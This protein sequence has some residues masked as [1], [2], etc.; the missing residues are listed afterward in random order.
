MPTDWDEL[1][2]VEEPAIEVLKALGYIYVPPEELDKEREGVKDVI[3]VPRLEKALRRINPWISDENVKRAVRAIGHVQATSLMEANEQV[4]TALVHTISLEQDIGQG[5]KG[6]PVHFIDFENIGN[7]EFVVTR[8]FKVIGQK[9]SIQADIVIYVNG[10]PLAV[11]ECKS[12]TI[13][14]PVEEGITQL[15]RY[16]ESDEKYKGLGAPKLFESCQIVAVVCRE[17]ARY[18][19]LWTQPRFWSEWKTTFPLSLDEIK[20]RIGRLP[21]EQDVLLYG[22]L[23]HGNLLNLIRDFIVFDIEKGKTIKKLARY[24]QF[25][26]VSHA[27]ERIKKTRMPKK[28]GG[29]VWHTQG[30][31][32]SLTML[33]LA[34]KLRRMSEFENPTLII[35]TDRKDL[36]R[37]INKTFKNC[38]FAN[39][40]RAKS[41]E[42]LRNLLT[43]GIGQ[44]VLTTIQKFTDASQVTALSEATNIF[45]MTDEAHRTEYGILAAKMRRA[46]PNAC[47]IAF[48]GTPI[49]KR[50]RSTLRT[51]GDYIHTYTI[52][53]AVQDDATVPIYYESRLPEVQIVGNTIDTLFE[54]WF[55]DYAPEQREEIKRRYATE[56]VIG[57]SA[58]RIERVC[59][60]IIEHFE[61]FIMPNGFKAQIVAPSREA[62]ITYYE[63][64]NRLNAPSS[65]VLIS[66]AHN[67]PERLVSH[68]KTEAEEK[69]IIRR[70]I[71]ESVEDLAIIIVCDKLLTGFDAPIE[72]VMY[73]DKPL[74]EHTLLQ[75]I[76]R[77]NRNYESKDYGLVVDY[78]GV[79]RELQEALNVFRPE[80][81]IGVQRYFED[82]LPRLESR[83]R[84]VMRFFDNVNK[85][86]INECIAVL[87]PEDVRA[88]F[89]SAFRR[90][91]KS[92]DMMLPDPKALRYVA[93]LKWLGQVRNAARLRYRDDTLD[94]SGCGAKVKQL[95]EEHL[96]VTGITKLIEP[97]SIFSSKFEEE[98]AKLTSPE[99]KASEMEHAIRYEINIRLEENP[100]YYQSLKERLEQIIEQRKQERIDAIKQLELLEKLAEEMKNLHKVAES[101]GMTEA[102]FAFYKLLSSGKDDKTKNAKDSQVSD[103]KSTYEVIS[104]SHKELASLIIESLEKLIVI[105]WMR[106]EDIQR[107]MRRQIKRHLRAAGYRPEEIEHLT[108]KMMDLARVRFTHEGL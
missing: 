94:L 91:S 14:N 50:E 67:D 7:N 33:W 19:T 93:D 16:Q 20:S 86:N 51:F 13:R 54:R 56:E 103:I 25:L 36:D 104:E 35:V 57:Q 52:E 29:V 77:V 31:G 88:D 38:G 74:R 40:L 47:F 60:D 55:K 83:H 9:V 24:P 5:K 8:Q 18:G 37:Q 107:E 6:Q 42:D 44:T 27:I 48:T 59:L 26:A 46:L 61:K 63:T 15:L 100:V 90:F 75:A 95:I 97:V 30:A 85:A 10:I 45:V 34:T 108:L 98:L 106:K 21:L 17:S 43:A 11:I 49:D 58:K 62:A 1:H 23:A 41:G 87:E 71:E 81:I 68:Y 99:A 32:K 78:W 39:P 69:E 70:F 80:D 89:D 101:I 22:M 28:R 4:Y 102:E 72:Q 3:L 65:E 96:T 53:Q 12:P 105:D 64:F 82:E 79:S 2:L 66:P 76:A 92:M 73:L 84:A